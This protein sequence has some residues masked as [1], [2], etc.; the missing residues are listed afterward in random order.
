MI[1]KEILQKKSIIQFHNNIPNQKSGRE[2]ETI[3]VAIIKDSE[4]CFLIEE[5]RRKRSKKEKLIKSRM[6]TEGGE[7][8]RETTRGTRGERERE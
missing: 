4:K 2:R 8:E 7:R 1:V 6:K 3:T 5:K